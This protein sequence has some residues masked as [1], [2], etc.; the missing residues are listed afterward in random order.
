MHTESVYAFE[1]PISHIAVPLTGVLLYQSNLCLCRA[2]RLLVQQSW[3]SRTEL[4]L[5]RLDVDMPGVPDQCG[6]VELC[7]CRKGVCKRRYLRT[8][9]RTYILGILPI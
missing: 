7:A 4:D 5:V 2:K 9:I 8:H 1:L 6:A 3:L